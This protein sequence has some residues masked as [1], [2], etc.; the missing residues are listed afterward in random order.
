MNNKRKAGNTGHVA[1]RWTEAVADDEGQPGQCSAE[2]TS[3]H[4]QHTMMV[5]I[6]LGSLRQRLSEGFGGPLA[7]HVKEYLGLS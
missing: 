6:K 3:K 2:T 1:P 5:I 4:D 7:P